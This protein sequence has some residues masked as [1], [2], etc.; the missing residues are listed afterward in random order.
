VILAADSTTSTGWTAANTVA[1]IVAAIAFAGV[2]VGVL[3]KWSTDR[4]E[5]WWNRTQ[6]ALE[7]LEKGE[8]ARTCALLVLASQLDSKQATEDDRSLMDD[9]SSIVLSEADGDL[10]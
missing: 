1:L 6:W 9:I 7:Q 8:E 3:Q 4:R 2:V 10:A 5:Q